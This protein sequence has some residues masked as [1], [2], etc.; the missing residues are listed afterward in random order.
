MQV[1]M[2]DCG[3]KDVTSAML[4]LCDFAWPPNISWQQ[5]GATSVHRQAGGTCIQVSITVCR[6]IV[7]LVVGGMHDGLKVFGVRGPADLDG[8]Q[9]FAIMAIPR[10]LG[11]AASAFGALAA[12]EAATKVVRVITR[13]A[14]AGRIKGTARETLLREC[15]WKYALV[16]ERQD[17]SVRF[18][19]GS[20]RTRFEVLCVMCSTATGIYMFSKSA[21]ADSV[22]GST[23]FQTYG[24]QLLWICTWSAAAGFGA[25]HTVV[26]NTA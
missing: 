7:A 3:A 2:L 9:A 21:V 8:A 14:T 15:A 16:S 18:A 11:L 12:P 6:T 20:A 5:P 22:L 4:A 24:C 25:M 1:A 19:C 26:W 10:G 23:S 17:S 13:A